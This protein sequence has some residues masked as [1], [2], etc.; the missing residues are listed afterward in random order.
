VQRE[1][2]RLQQL[3][4]EGKIKPRGVSAAAKDGQTATPAGA[5][6]EVAS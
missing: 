4:K 3:V 1:K 6:A 5:S 2:K